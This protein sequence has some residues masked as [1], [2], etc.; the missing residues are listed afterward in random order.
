MRVIIL[1][2]LG[3]LTLVE[4]SCHVMMT[5]SQAYGEV[6]KARMW[7]SQHGFPV[8]LVNCFGSGS[9]IPVK[10]AFLAHLLTAIS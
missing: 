3:L 9:S 8:M 4:A 6:C 2:S 1:L 10:S 5:L 7:Q